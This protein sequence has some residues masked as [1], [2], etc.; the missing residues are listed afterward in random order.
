MSAAQRSGGDHAWYI[1][2]KH[3]RFPGLR[4][5]PVGRG[6]GDYVACVSEVGDWQ[7]SSPCKPVARRVGHITRSDPNEPSFAAVQ[8][9]FTN[10]RNFSR[11]YIFRSPDSAA[12]ATGMQGVVQ[13]AGGMGAWTSGITPLSAGEGAELGGRSAAIG[14]A[15][16]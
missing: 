4:R 3:P 9:S 2:D 10:L 11:V 6:Q 16:P 14:S 12:P 1:S 7:T 15:E 13:M 8:Q 5:E